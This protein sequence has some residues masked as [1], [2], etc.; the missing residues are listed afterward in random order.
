MEHTYSDVLN[1]ELGE[2]IYHVIPMEL[3][4][5]ISL[6]YIQQEHISNHVT[7]MWLVYVVVYSGQLV[8]VLGENYTIEDED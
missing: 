8:N 3:L 7:V 6:N 5:Y 2:A 4:C 1:E